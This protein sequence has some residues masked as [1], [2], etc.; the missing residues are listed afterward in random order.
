MQIERPFAAI[1]RRSAQRWRCPASLRPARTFGRRD[2]AFDGE[3]KTSDQRN[4]R[5]ELNVPPWWA[6]LQ[7]VGAPEIGAHGG[8]ESFDIA[9]LNPTAGVDVKRPLRIVA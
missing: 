3:T 7:V 5:E 9:S 1:A 4:L 8:G 2:L 6:T